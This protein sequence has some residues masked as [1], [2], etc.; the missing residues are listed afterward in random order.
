[1]RSITMASA[2]FT[3]IL[4]AGSANADELELVYNLENWG[5]DAGNIISDDID[6]GVGVASINSITVTLSH[7]WAADVELGLYAP[8]DDQSDTADLAGASYVLTNDQGSFNDFGTGG[9]TLADTFVYEFI[10]SGSANGIVG[11]IPGNIAAGTYDASSWG[12]G[13]SGAGWLL[14]LNDNAN[15]D[16][17]A[18]GTVT[19]DF[20]AVPEPTSALVILGLTAVLAGRR[21]R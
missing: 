5:L 16:D 11:A 12:A 19:I 17:G 14:V 4:L 18:I 6:F 7:S 8:T 10:A 20:N 21:R 1:M 9:S 3:A 13:G 15:G 2:V